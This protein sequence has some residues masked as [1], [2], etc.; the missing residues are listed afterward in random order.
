MNKVKNFDHTGKLRGEVKLP[1]EYVGKA[2]LYLLAQ[3]IRVYEDGLHLGL[4]K[5]KTRSQI[6]A[7]KKKVYRQK[8]TGQARHGAKSAPIFVGGSKAH[9][10]KGNKRVLNLPKKLKLKALNEALTIKAQRGELV[11]VSG[12][13]KVKKTS[14][15]KKLISS[16]IKSMGLEKTANFSFVFSD[17]DHEA[18]KFIRNISNVKI[19]VKNQINALRV[20]KGG[21]LVVDENFFDN[22]PEGK[23]DKKN[24]VKRK[25]DK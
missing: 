12:V 24:R 6:S 22:E 7:T 18:I 10:P 2:N 25:A 8:G 17:K 4:S 23:K 13:I 5:T 9:G 3:A 20:Y 15:V 19:L 14:E 16:L 11:V 21:I 1:K